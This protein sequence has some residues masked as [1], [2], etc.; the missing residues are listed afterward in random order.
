MTTSF[1]SITARASSNRNETKRSLLSAPETSNIT[2]RRPS[3][4][5]SS[6]RATTSSGSV[7]SVWLTCTITSPGLTLFSSAS[8]PAST[9]VTSTPSTLRRSKGLAR[10][11]G[12]RAEREAEHLCC[13]IS[14]RSGLISSSVGR[15]AS[16]RGELFVLQQPD[17]DLQR[18]ALAVAHHVTSTRIARRRVGDEP[19]QVA[20]GLDGLAVELDDDVA[21]LQA[22]GCRRAVVGNAGDQRAGRLGHAESLGDFVRHVLDA[23]ADP[24]AT[25][26]AEAPQLLD[27]RHGDF[28]RNRE[29][30]ADRAAGRRHDRGVDADDLAA[31][32]EQRPAGI[33]AVN[34]GIGLDV[35]VVR[36]GIDVAVESRDDARR[37]RAAEAER[38][39]DRQHPFADPKRV[40]AAEQRALSAGLPASTLSSARSVLSSMPTISALSWV[41]SAKLA[42]I[43]SA[44]AITWLLVTISPDG[45]MMKPEPS[46]C[47]VCGSP[48]RPPRSSSKKSSKKSS[49][50]GGAGALSSESGGVGCVGVDASSRRAAKSRCRR[51]SRAAA[52]QDRRTRRQRR[53]ARPEGRGTAAAGASFIGGS[54]TTGSP[55]GKSGAGRIGGGT[56][57]SG[58]TAGSGVASGAV[59]AGSG[60]QHVG[61]REMVLATRRRKGRGRHQ[62]QRDRDAPRNIDPSSFEFSPR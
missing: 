43:S 28:G 4:F 52:R 46:D 56:T 12:D 62:R 57:V 6:M 60:L 9:P 11:V 58:G 55:P 38:V 26:L 10:L 45:S 22:A 44:S 61:R 36:A 2:V 29:A 48:S 51:R 40:G 1:D 5:S 37:H 50:G 8:L 35:V 14:R 54:S 27:D 47:T 16:R 20:H 17:L 23:H 30:D 13:V 24:A 25:H 15:W 41:P 34:R 49:P 42:T 33:A 53:S 39:A 19:R 31:D 3:V 32:V 59:W 7:T 21:F 18:D